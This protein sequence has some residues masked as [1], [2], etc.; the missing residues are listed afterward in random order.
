[1]WKKRFEVTVEWQPVHAPW[2]CN[3]MAIRNIGANPVFV[4]TET[5]GD[6]DNDVLL[7]GIQE[8]VTA[9]WLPESYNNQATRYTRIQRVFDVRCDTGLSS[10]VIVTWVR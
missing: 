6:Y 2:D 3:Y 8:G 7:P 4:R 9:P 5:A 10:T 1:M